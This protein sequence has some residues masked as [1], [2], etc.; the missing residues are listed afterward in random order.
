MNYNKKLTITWKG[1]WKNVRNK[2]VDEFGGHI[3]NT[4]KF[5]DALEGFC[6]KKKIN[7][8]CIESCDKWKIADDLVQHRKKKDYKIERIKLL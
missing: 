6:S 3:C 7:L 1:W 4:C 8:H 5:Y 2:L